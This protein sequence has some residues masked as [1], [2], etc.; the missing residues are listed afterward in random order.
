MSTEAQAA[1]SLLGR[2]TGMHK[3][4]AAPCLQVRAA[5]LGVTLEP[6]Y[7]IL[8]GFL[9]FLYILHLYW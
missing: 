4:C 1:V 8:N 5:E 6:H 7:S 3:Q 2:S 9:I